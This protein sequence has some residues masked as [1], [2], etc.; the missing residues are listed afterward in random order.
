MSQATGM[1][2]QGLA[3]AGGA[4]LG[5]V[6]A[7]VSS[8]SRFEEQMRNVNSIAHLSEAEFS[9]L[10]E[11][12]RNMP[13]LE[14]ATQGPTELAAAL[15][16]IQSS[17]F[18]GAKGLQVLRASAKAA[19]AG[20]TSTKTAAEA[21]AGAL[22]AFSLDANQSKRVSDV[23]FKTVESGVITFEQLAHSFGNIS[24]TAA[25]AGLSIEETT[26][27]IA[28]LTLKGV[29]PEESV[30]SLN[31]AILHLVAPGKEA[32][33][34]MKS[35]GIHIDAS[36]LKSRGLVWAMGELYQ[37]TGGSLPLLKK[38]LEDT[39]AI[40]AVTAITNDGGQALVKSVDANKD[41]SGA[42]ERARAEQ[43]KSMAFQMRQLW[44]QLEA[45]AVRV[46]QIVAPY[47]GMAAKAVK[48][49]SDAFA[50]LSPKTQEWVVIATSVA[51]AAASAAGGIILL[52]P[53]IATLAGAGPAILGVAAALAAGVAAVGAFAAAWVNNWGDIQGVAATSWESIKA[54]AAKVWEVLKQGWE[55]VS[56]VGKDAL[57]GDWQQAW[58]KTKVYAGQAWEAVKVYGAQA[59]EAA[60]GYAAQAW[61]WIYQKI[62]EM[63]KAAWEQVKALGA[64]AWEW[65]LAKLQ[66]ADITGLTNDMAA[67]LGESFGRAFSQGM[68][69]GLDDKAF[70]LAFPGMS[71]PKSPS[72]T[73]SGT[74]G[75]GQ[76]GAA[77]PESTQ[78]GPT[79]ASIGAPAQV[80]P[81]TRKMTLTPSFNAAL[82]AERKNFWEGRQIGKSFLSAQPSIEGTGP[83]R[84][85]TD[86]DAK[87]AEARAEAPK[88]LVKG[89]QGRLS[90]ALANAGDDPTE[91]KAALQRAL[92]ELQRSELRDK[93]EV[94]Q[95]GHELRVQIIKEGQKEQE[96]ADKQAF[97]TWLSTQDRYLAEL[98]KRAGVSSET[99]VA[100]LR[101]QGAEAQA[102]LNS[103]KARGVKD[104]DSRVQALKRRVADRETGV[105]EQKDA[106]AKK[107]LD[108]QEKLLESR[109]KASN[110]ELDAL[111][112]RVAQG[113]ATEAELAAAFQRNLD[114]RLAAV[115]E[116]ARK[117]RLELA[118]TAE[119]E[120]AIAAV[121]GA[122]KLEI[123]EEE[124][125]K[126]KETVDELRKA[127]PQLD[128]TKTPGQFSVLK[129]PDFTLSLP[130]GAAGGVSAG[131]WRKDPNQT[132]GGWR[133]KAAATDKTPLQ[134]FADQLKTSGDNLA[135]ALNSAATKLE[136]AATRLANSMAGGSAGSAGGGNAGSAGGTTVQIN[137]APRTTT[138]T[139]NVQIGTGGGRQ[140][141]PRLRS[142]SD[143]I[144][145]Q[146]N[147]DLSTSIRGPLESVRSYD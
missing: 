84:K 121:V 118:N 122:K 25:A 32:S 48:T 17:G 111:K 103:L 135:G 15:Y 133:N 64:Q 35:L 131:D 37:K 6:G 120:V 142:L 117:Q 22:N 41:S 105:D 87:A 137:E 82:T 67:K 19:D 97:S 140:A 60:K 33:D 40:K 80:S 43:A 134:V 21:I 4:T 57:S 13:R 144:I 81:T 26:G 1:I 20:M 31:Q 104:G 83:F 36:T 71:R 93:P 147:L 126:A 143:H 56:D 132:A 112:E 24:S 55:A 128:A 101:Q 65:I 34:T 91:R 85:Q 138:T 88:K 114:L 99:I 70:S 7:T 46:G 98:R 124:R 62:I 12:I 113:K 127:Q 38:I 54:G 47:V 102:Q 42:A 130:N 119:N 18:E 74:I 5:G 49:L 125:K 8:F 146:I 2:G 39:N 58:E 28:A 53:V 51:G 59:W 66:S 90:E 29:S 141:S 100:Y 75:L 3:V 63:A 61:S 95:K 123:R 92:A 110:L 50:S 78:N 27:A 96:K 86:A 44:A 45:G 14:G 115:D 16:Q 72:T 77:A 129:L 30:N 145:D 139:T 23:F 108:L 94:L 11:T 79:R 107:A 136:A 9:K 52:A 109:Q 116:E 69:D 10:S 106:Q 76:M 73:S 68:Q 89:V